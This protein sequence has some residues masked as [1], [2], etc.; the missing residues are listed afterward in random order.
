MNMATYIAS[1]RATIATMIEYKSA[2]TQR[3]VR[4]WIRWGTEPAVQTTHTWLAESERRIGE[5]TCT[6]DALEKRRRI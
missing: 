2:I 1:L 6:A 4:G 3:G 5:L